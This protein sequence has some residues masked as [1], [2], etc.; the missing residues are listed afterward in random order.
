MGTKTVG[1]LIQFKVNGQLYP[2][3]GD[4]TFNPGAPKRET[5]IGSDAPHGVKETPQ[6]PFIEGEVTDTGELDMME[7]RRMKGATVYLELA[8][9]KSFVLRDACYAGDGTQ[10]TEEGNMDVRFEGRS[11]EI[12]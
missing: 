1:G 10:H 4:F 2:A 9:G 7:L 5:V 6:V 11:G 12:V 8:N 3:K